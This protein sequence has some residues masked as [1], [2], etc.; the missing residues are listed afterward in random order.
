MLSG[1]FSD[2]LRYNVTSEK[3][4]EKKEIA[5]RKF[6]MSKKT[7]DTFKSSGLCDDIDSYIQVEGNY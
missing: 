2:V 1:K 5:F 6:E 3:G 7:M 4:E